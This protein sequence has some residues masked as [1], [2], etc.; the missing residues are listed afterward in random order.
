MYMMNDEY[1]HKPISSSRVV[2]SIYA[3]VASKFQIVFQ[4]HF[5]CFRIYYH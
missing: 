3:S 4:V 5:L 2:F 1:E